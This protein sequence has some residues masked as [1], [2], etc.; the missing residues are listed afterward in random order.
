ASKEA[1]DDL[2]RLGYFSVFK[3]RSLTELKKLKFSPLSGIKDMKV[4][5]TPGHTRGSICL[6]DKRRKILFSGDTLFHNGII[7]RVDLP[8]SAPDKMQ[9]SLDKLKICHYK[10]LCPGH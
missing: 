1:V 2:K 6:W 4:V 5:K 3:L 7:G 8:D 10:L 9:P